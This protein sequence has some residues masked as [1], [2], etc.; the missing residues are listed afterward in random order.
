MF[1]VFVRLWI[2][3]ITVRDVST[4]GSS[5]AT[6]SKIQHFQ[7]NSL[8]IVDDFLQRNNIKNKERS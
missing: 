6:S 2:E 5:M 1:M 3:N 7:I 4:L 8:R